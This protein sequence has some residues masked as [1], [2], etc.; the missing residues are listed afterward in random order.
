MSTTLAVRFPLGRYHAN[1]WDRAVNEGVTEW[2][3]SPWRIL[4]ALV[5]TWHTRWP[6]LPAVVM[7]GILDALADPPSYWTPPTTAGHTR[8]YLPDL[9]HRK[10]E[11][12]STD[13]TLDPFLSVS[14]Q[15]ELKI[16]WNADLDLEQREALKKLAELLPYLGRAE[17]V[18]EARVLDE[19]P[20]TDEHWWRPN[21]D[22]KIRVRLLAPTRPVSRE[23]L[24]T[25]TTDVRKRRR[26]VPPG[27]TWVTYAVASPRPAEPPR[28]R[29]TGIDGL[30][31]VRFALIG[32]VPMRATQGLVLTDLVHREAGKVL[33]DEVTDKRRRDIM[34]TDGASTDHL[35]AHW[36]A[37]PQTWNRGSLCQSLVAWVPM[38][39]QTE[40]LR[41]LLNVR[42]VS[43]RLGG[44]DGY[45]VAGFPRGLELRF[46]AAGPIE[47]VAPEICGPKARRWRSLTPYL[48]VRHWKRETLD[49]FVAADIAAELSYLRDREFPDVRVSRIESG[50]GMT[51]RWAS[52]FRRHRLKERR[53][54]RRD[55][56][57]SWASRPGMGLRLE[58]AEPVAGPLLLGQLSHFG[59]GLFVPEE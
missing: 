8:H 7:D 46:Q 54:G 55:D 13:L 21:A 47:Q 25:T 32:T 31:A 27:T 50:P 29:G 15:A 9:E 23:V 11:T 10:G 59:F 33:K 14:S 5:A 36:I 19:E 6:D 30:T 17:S 38:G 39:L 35:H 44:P 40:E 20:V 43:G 48:P 51:D 37:V 3:P 58:F 12:G 4:R 53:G 56:K 49:E 2:P 22:G 52:E 1:P 18:C 34:G 45:E 24:E 42:S 57:R 26:T 16:R 28:S 41:A